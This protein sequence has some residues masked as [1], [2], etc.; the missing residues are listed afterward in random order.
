[1]YN[2]I[3]SIIIAIVYIVLL[4]SSKFIYR[5]IINP[6]S[7][8]TSMWLGFSFISC[9]GF[10]DMYIPSYETISFILIATLAFSI[11]SLVYYASSKKKCDSKLDFND[12]VDTSKLEKKIEQKILIINALALLW[13]SKFISKMLPIILSGDWNLARYY[14]LNASTVHTVYTTKESLLCQWIIYPIFYATTIYSAYLFSIK[15]INYKIMITSLIGVLSIVISTAGRNSLFKLIIFYAIAF[16]FKTNRKI[17]IWKKIKQM[18]IGIKVL[19]VVGV[20]ILVY[21]SS[22]RSLSSNISVFQNV[23]FYFTGPIVYFDNIIKN[24]SFFGLDVDLL[25]GKATFGFLTTPIEI[26]ASSLSGG[27]YAGA[28]NIITS[29]VNYYANF[30]PTIKGNAVSTSLYPFM[31]DFGYLGIL[32]G[33]VI[34]ALIVNY[35]YTK[36]MNLY[37]DNYVF[38]NCLSIYML[39]I[40]F[41]SEWQYDLLFPSSLAIMAVLYMLVAKKPFKFKIK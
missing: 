34:F 20:Y 35:V 27:N 19:L 12:N 31:K 3:L 4:I 14:Y 8:F 39:Y 29:Y 7:I 11:T 9:F 25:W 28:D 40:V 1:M 33:P 26:I 37:N 36:S 16:L 13:M 38:W 24:P 30:S 5:N 2:I 18:S 22:K 6:V 17:S 32:I 10:W 15:K 41:F 21:I 23:M